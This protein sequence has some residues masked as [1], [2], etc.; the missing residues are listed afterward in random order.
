MRKIVI[1]HNWGHF[2]TWCRDNN[3]NPNDWRSVMY[4]TRVG[5]ICGLDPRN[6]EIVDLWQVNDVL[7]HDGRFIDFVR[8][9]N[10]DIKQ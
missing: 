1:A 4:V 6:C 2:R 3:L 5:Q 7:H 10:S 9:C 8:R